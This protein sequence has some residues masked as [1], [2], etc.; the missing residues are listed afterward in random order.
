MTE[1]RRSRGIDAVVVLPPPVTGMTLVTERVLGTRPAGRTWAFGRPGWLRPMAAW[2]VYKQV[3]LLLLTAICAVSARADGREEP[4][5][6]VYIVA[7]SG[8]VGWLLTFARAYILR[9]AYCHV[10]VHHHTWDAALSSRMGLR[11]VS[12]DTGVYHLFLCEAMRDAYMGAYPGLVSHVVPNGAWQSMEPER[13]IQ[14]HASRSVL[15]GPPRFG[16]LSNLTPDKGLAALCALAR[17]TSAD[18]QFELAGPVA[19][20]V[21]ASMLREL[22]GDARFRWHGPLYGAA[23]SAFLDG[24]DIF[25][26]PST[27]RS[28]A[29]P[30]VVDEAID[31]GCLVIA[32]DTRCI[33]EQ[34]GERGWLIPSENMVSELR[35]L[36]EEL[37]R[38]AQTILARMRRG[39][40]PRRGLGGV[41]LDEVLGTLS[42]ECGR[43]APS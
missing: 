20:G 35:E 36:V 2:R 43:C 5:R 39:R 42:E 26:F 7:D 14:R 41:R 27:Y 10:V 16:L 3:R 38:D 9:L 4:G 11:L 12:E 23:K 29:Q 37:C 15:G 6:S 34:V 13:G 18:F 1:P 22:L 17:T 31:H 33:P 30:L 40:E 21:G 32:P 8:P 25:V 19:D 24:L 28:E